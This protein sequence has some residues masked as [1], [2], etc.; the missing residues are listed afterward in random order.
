MKGHRRQNLHFVFSVVV[1]TPLLVMGIAEGFGWN[2]MELQD[3]SS[4][5][6]VGDTAEGLQTYRQPRHKIDE[7]VD[8][9]EGSDQAFP[10]SR[11]YTAEVV[12]DIAEG[13]GQAF[14]HSHYN[15]AEVVPDIAEDADQASPHSHHHTAEA[16]WD[17][18]SEHQTPLLPA[19]AGTVPLNPSSPYNHAAAA[20][21]AA[22]LKS[23]NPMLQEY[24]P[25]REEVRML[26][27]IHAAAVAAAAEEA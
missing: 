5:E 23:P 3:L 13:A 12:P 6:V 4:E 9:A 11:H 2:L 1:R 19:V 26:R 8:I 21:A 17:T 14:P 16:G 18:P 7:D 25:V 20:A 24:T 15:T 22:G 27:R 10:H